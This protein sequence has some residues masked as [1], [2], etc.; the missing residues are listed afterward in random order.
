VERKEI[1]CLAN[2]RKLNAYCVAGIDMTSGEWIRP[3]GSGDHGA[4]TRA[5]QT[6]EDGSRPQLLDVI[7]I[8]LARPVPEPGQPE[9]WELASGVWKARDRL[10]QREARELLERIA[11]DDPIFGTNARGFSAAAVEA[12]AVAS[13][14]AVV[15]PADLTWSKEIRFDRVKLRARFRHAGAWHDLGV[16]DLAWIAEFADDELGTYAHADTEDVFLVV[17]LA[18]PF[19]GEHF[20]L[21]AGVICLDA[22]G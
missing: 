1:V 9:N 4:V 13:S 21:V 16:T 11:V 6:L 20:K 15:R 19:H 2:S 7:E 10:D 22:E 8:P 5:E 3:T 14:L 12:G 18:E 17:S